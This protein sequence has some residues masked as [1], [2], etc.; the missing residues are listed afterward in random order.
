MRC[1]NNGMPQLRDAPTM[2][3][4]DPDYGMPQLWDDTPDPVVRG[5]AISLVV[6]GYTLKIK[7]LVWNGTPYPRVG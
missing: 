7:I 6:E 5:Y 4:P 3:W 2:G 1:P